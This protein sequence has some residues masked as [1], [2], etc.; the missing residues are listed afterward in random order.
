MG[1]MRHSKITKKSMIL[2]NNSTKP[3]SITE[4]HSK[5]ILTLKLMKKFGG[6]KDNSKIFKDDNNYKNNKD[7]K[8]TIIEAEV[9]SAK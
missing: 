3:L 7:T 5:T 6:L 1:E 8:E 9:S 2:F 4:L